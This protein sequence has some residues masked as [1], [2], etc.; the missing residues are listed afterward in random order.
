[1]ARRPLPLAAQPRQRRQRPAAELH[2]R[3]RCS[4]PL[5]L[6][7]RQ[8]VDGGPPAAAA[9][10][11]ASSAPRAARR[12]RAARYRDARRPPMLRAPCSRAPP[13]GVRWPTGRCRWRLSLAIALPAGRFLYSAAS[14]W[15]VDHRPLPLAAQPRQRHANAAT[16][17]EG[18]WLISYRRP[19]A[20]RSG[21]RCRGVA[22][23]QGRP[24]GP[25]QWRDDTS[26]DA[27]SG[28][29]AGCRRAPW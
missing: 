25:S 27:A 29:R 9:G 6:E 18:P 11:P 2:A 13:A 21:L 1:M 14:G 16:V 22:T 20:A 4:G 8:R 19:P 17:D 3:R 24:P 5:A 15:M 12:R 28:G 7:R 10:C 23:R 26:H